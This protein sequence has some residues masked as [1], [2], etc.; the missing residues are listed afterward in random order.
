M[1][2]SNA[3]NLFINITITIICIISFVFLFINQKNTYQGYE[4][5]YLMPLS[6]L[7][8]HMFFIRKVL[9]NYGLSIFL[10]VYILVSLTRVVILPF[11]TLESG[12]YLGRA[13]I[14]PS[15][16]HFRKAI[17]LIIYET[18]CYHATVYL[19]HRM[20]F[21][22][23][24]HN[25]LLNKE[26]LNFEFNSFIYIIFILF[27]ISTIIIKPSVIKNISFISVNSSYMS[28]REVYTLTSLIILLL[29]FLRYLLYFIIVK[30]II[31]YIQPKHF[32]LSI[33]LVNIVTILNA[34][35]FFGTNLADFVFT[36]IVSL[37]IL[38]YLYGKYGIALNL[39][40]ISL[41]PFVINR[42]SS[43]RKDS[44]ITDG[45]GTM[46]VL[47]DKLQVYLGGIYN[48]AISLD[49]PERTGNILLLLADIFRS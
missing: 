40:F 23:Q 44:T 38:V 7:F 49:L 12:W 28:L 9:T 26:R 1:Y 32:I 47:T 20:I 3:L 41:L 24:K 15:P 19:A 22:N 42:I 34:L 27:S 2:K 29:T 48:V 35:I 30:F 46:V 39:V 10:A 21:K 45:E 31:K 33:I 17:F 36:F 16:Y 8:F 14:S 6:Y 25:K 4:L 11:L 13:K 37:I 18:F 5:M 43:Y